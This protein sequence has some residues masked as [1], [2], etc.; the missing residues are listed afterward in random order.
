M[1]DSMKQPTLYLDTTQW[2]ATDAQ[3]QWFNGRRSQFANH[4]LEEVATWL[5]S[6]GRR[7]CSLAVIL[8]AASHLA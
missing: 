8:S 7:R 2:Y 1:H 5:A 4:P 3:G 6:L